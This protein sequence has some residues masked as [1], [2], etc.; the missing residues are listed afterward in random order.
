MRLRF[1]RSATR[2]QVSRDRS[3]YVIE[4]CGLPFE[5][6]EDS[7]ATLFLG[8]DWNGV[9]VEVGAVERGDELLVV[10]AMR[11]RPKFRAMYE[12]ALPWRH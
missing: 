11:L 10:H 7:A 5:G 2:H 6:V 8:D 9:P 3:A 12:E 4:H 1:A